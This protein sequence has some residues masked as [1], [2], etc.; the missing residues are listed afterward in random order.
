MNTSTIVATNFNNR[1]RCSL[2]QV[3]SIPQ[4]MVPIS[5]VWNPVPNFSTIESIF[6]MK[7]V[8][9]CVYVRAV[10]TKT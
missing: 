4:M 6:T 10:E 5:A 9:V 8:Y 1:H 2:S 3:Y 7:S